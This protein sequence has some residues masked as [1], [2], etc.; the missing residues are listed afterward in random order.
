M[1][2]QPHTLHEGPEFAVK[3]PTHHE[4]PSQAVLAPYQM[5]GT[6]TCHYSPVPMVM[7]CPPPVY[8]LVQPK[9]NKMGGATSTQKMGRQILSDCPETWQAPT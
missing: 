1:P 7:G 3:S 2:L 4:G 6:I 9:G 8:P 5:L